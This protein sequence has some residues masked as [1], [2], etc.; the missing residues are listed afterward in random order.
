MSR[1]INPT[2]LAEIVTKLLDG[3]SGELCEA[4]TYAHFMTEIANVICDHCGGEVW[5]SAEYMDDE[6][7]VGI[8]R[9]DGQP[10]DGGIWCG[11]DDDGDD[12]FQT[13]VVA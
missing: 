8:H 5:D 2:E 9:S 11:Y 1:H 7:F 13:G 10:P 12:D 6:W 4:T 3:N